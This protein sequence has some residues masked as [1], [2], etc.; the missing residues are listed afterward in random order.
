M[1]SHCRTLLGRRWLRCRWLLGGSSE[2][3]LDQRG[4]DVADELEDPSPSGRVTVGVAQSRQITTAPT[5]TQM[6]VVCP[7][8]PM[9]LPPRGRARMNA[10]S[11]K[12]GVR[13]PKMTRTKGASESPPRLSRSSPRFFEGQ[14]R[15]LGPGIGRDC[16]LHVEALQI[17]RACSTSGD[18]PSST[19]LVVEIRSSREKR[20]PTVPVSGSTGHFAPPIEMLPAVVACS[21]PIV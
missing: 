20:A 13:A 16:R 19:D 12:R 15:L 14:G 10:M 7:L 9:P 4:A 6:R 2:N 5:R 11:A 3:A 1:P 18:A 17:V 8:P 21:H